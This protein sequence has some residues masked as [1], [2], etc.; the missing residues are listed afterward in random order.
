[1][2]GRRAGKTKTRIK[3]IEGGIARSRLDAVA[4][5]EPLEI[6]LSGTGFAGRVAVTMRTPGSD[7]ELAAG[8]L[9]SEGLI[10]SLDE[11]AEIGYCVDRDVVGDQQYNVVTVDLRPHHQVDAALVNRQFGMTSACGVCGKA[12]LDQIER[13]GIEPVSRGP[14]I[15]PELLYSFPEKLRSAQGIFDATGGLHAAGLFTAEGKL[16]ALREDVGRHNAVDKLIGWALLQGRLPLD[17]QIIMVS[18]RTSFEIAQKCAAAGV[19]ILC[20]VS[21]PSSL[22]IDLARRFRMTLIG[23]LRGDRFNIYT[24]AERIVLDE[25]IPEL[26]PGVRTPVQEA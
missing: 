21:A 5:E 24:G 12:S 13:R 14:S 4:T 18:G 3:V 20:A 23:F 17:N 10:T 15:T 11:I 25:T 9:F 8:F 22:A 1:M 2:E 19:P 6:R 26:F 7:Y 16:L